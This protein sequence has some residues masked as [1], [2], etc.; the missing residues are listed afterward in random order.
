MINRSDSEKNALKEIK[1][2]MDS[3]PRSV[4]SQSECGSVSNLGQINV[5]KEFFFSVPNK[6]D[7]NGY[8]TINN[9]NNNM[10]KNNNDNKKYIL[11]DENNQNNQINQNNNHNNNKNENNIYYKYDVD[12]NNNDIYIL[13][14]LN[15]I[16]DTFAIIKPITAINNSE[17]IISVILGHGFEIIKQL[18]TI[19]TLEQVELFYAEHSGRTFFGKLTEYMC[20]GPIIALQLRR[21]SAVSGWRHLIG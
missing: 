16:E 20:S 1:F 5:I 11:I 7:N 9:I 13:N 10:N 12:S 19:L 18:K 8:Y 4:G 3:D 21:V 17:E 2:W 14:G 6:T 15:N